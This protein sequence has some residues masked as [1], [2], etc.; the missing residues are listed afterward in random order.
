MRGGRSFDDT[1]CMLCDSFNMRCTS[2]YVL[3]CISNIIQLLTI[4]EDNSIFVWPEYRSRRLSVADSF[5]GQSKLILSEKA[6]C[7]RSFFQNYLIL[8]IWKLLFTFTYV[9]SVKLDNGFISY[10]DIVT[11]KWR[12]VLNQWK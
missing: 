3:P 10:F 2:C 7:S 5:E 1:V 12:D 11:S 4:L 9:K 8:L 6:F